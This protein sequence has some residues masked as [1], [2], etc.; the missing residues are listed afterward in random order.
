MGVRMVTGPRGCHKCFPCPDAC[1][2][3][4]LSQACRR[5]QGAKVG[6]ALPTAGRHYIGPMSAMARIRPVFGRWYR[7]RRLRRWHTRQKRWHRSVIISLP[8][9]R[10]LSFLRSRFFRRVL[11]ASS[12]MSRSPKVIIASHSTKGLL[13]NGAENRGFWQGNRKR[14]EYHV[15]VAREVN[16]TPG[17][18][19]SVVLI[20]FDERLVRRIQNGRMR[21]GACRPAIGPNPAG[22]RQVLTEQSVTAS[23]HRT[24][25]PGSRPG[26][27]ASRQPNSLRP[28]HPRPTLVS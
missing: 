22:R 18:P 11:S 21:P 3:T 2:G 14:H 1:Q 28:L 13:R 23:C 12:S 8:Q 16:T 4:P 15:S 5:R 17:A 27:D 6:S 25:P 19:S 9:P 7:L 10:H 20:R 24:D 26:P